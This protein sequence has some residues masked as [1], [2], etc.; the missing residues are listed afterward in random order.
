[1]RIVSNCTVL[2]VRTFWKVFKILRTDTV[3]NIPS[4]TLFNMNSMNVPIVG[5]GIRPM[6]GRK[7]K[8]LFKA[9][10]R[11]IFGIF[12]NLLIIMLSVLFCY[13]IIQILGSEAHRFKQR[14]HYIEKK[15]TFK[16]RVAN[17]S[18]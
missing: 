12:F 5:G 18:F 7:F 4:V 10:R 9:T 11:E 15:G 14:Q 2:V 17:L 13:L 8:K 6:L 16:P 1:M 3:K